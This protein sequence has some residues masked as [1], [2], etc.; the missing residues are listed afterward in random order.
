MG[1]ESLGASK[2]GC[3]SWTFITELYLI[4]EESSVIWQMETMQTAE[5]REYRKAE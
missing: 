1:L 2:N 5:N 4:H 3:C